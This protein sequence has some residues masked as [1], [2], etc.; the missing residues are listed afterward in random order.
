MHRVSRFREHWIAACLFLAIG[1]P[2]GAV[3]VTSCT[4]MTDG[5]VCT[6]T[7]EMS[8]WY[9]TLT[10]VGAPA[11]EQS[12]L[13]STDHVSITLSD[14]INLDSSVDPRVIADL[15]PFVL[16]SVG[17]IEWV[18]ADPENLDANGSL[19]SSY[20]AAAA[21]LESLFGPGTL[22]LGGVTSSNAR[23]FMGSATILCNPGNP[24][25][26]A[27]PQGEDFFLATG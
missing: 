24:P 13:S 10:V 18:L 7:R 15:A 17:G 5:A 8:F 26:C 12:F 25:V 1:V 3:P 19:L 20:A 21:S 16:P 22:S 9:G 14:A 27:D 11:S 4:D 2:A 23:Y 6:L